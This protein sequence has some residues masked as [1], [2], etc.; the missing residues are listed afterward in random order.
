M[1]G[2][3]TATQ[4]GFW[5]I[6]IVLLLLIFI[7]LPV[8]LLTAISDSKAL[9]TQTARV[10]SNSAI[11]ARYIAKQL[12]LGLTSKA[13]DSS[14]TIRLSE[15]ELNEALALAVR[16]IPSTKSRARIDAGKLLAELTLRLPSNPLGEYL[17]V[18]AV[19][20]PFS[21][22]LQ[23]SQLR[24]GNLNLSGRILL[25]VVETLLN[26]ALQGEALGSELMAAVESLHINESRI[27]LVYHPVANFR[28]KLKQLK[29][30]L[31]LG[32]D[33][34]Y[35]VR[36][37]YL[38]LCQF[39][40]QG[41]S[42][43]YEALSA[44]LSHIFTY[45]GQQ[46]NNIEQAVAENQAALLAMALFLGSERFD[47]LIG[48]LN[49]ETRKR[50]RSPDGYIGLAN[51][52]DLRLHFVFSAAL[53]VIANSGISFSIGEYKELLDTEQGGSG[54]SFADLAADRA[55]IRFAEFAVDKSSAVQLQNRANK[56]SHEGLF[57]PS[58]SAL[59]EGIE[60]QDFERRG[61]IES[62]FYRQYLAVIER[63]IEQLPLYQIR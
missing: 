8:V 12:Y 29:T 55:G 24:V 57:F 1:R 37:Y 40:Q 27:T 47:A 9:V 4:R 63:R 20:E 11:K 38:Q 61:G 26:R 59:P 52:N 5:R 28:S 17:N 35:R 41:P 50:C 22:G 51:R 42:E 60:Q 15:D 39:R 56:L 13:A 10:D 6:S 30:Q 44:Y 23:I 21:D 25:G 7:A 2:G 43:G 58:I 53:Q 33:D 31:Q 54:F 32:E 46:S 36:E 18:T 14:A 3:R 34:S 48:A 45:A 19:I 49:W 16:G 62:D